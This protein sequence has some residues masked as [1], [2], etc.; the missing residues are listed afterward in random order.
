MDYCEGLYI[1]PSDS[2]HPKCTQKCPKTGY[3]YYNITHHPFNYCV[4][5]CENGYIDSL[6]NLNMPTCVTICNLKNTSYYGVKTE[7]PYCSLECP[8]DQPYL[9]IIS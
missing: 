6:T 2:E 4:A 9:D 1:D 5:K 8:E 3:P 7:N